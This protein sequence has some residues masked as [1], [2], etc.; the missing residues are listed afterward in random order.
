MAA[1]TSH[2]EAVERELEA[3]LWSLRQ[4]A[5]RERLADLQRRIAGKRPGGGGS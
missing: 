5:F 1:V 2:E 4:P 3:Q